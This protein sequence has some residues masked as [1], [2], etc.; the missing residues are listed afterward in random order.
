MKKTF[1]LSL[2]FCLAL[3]YQLQAQGFSYSGFKGGL[4]ISRMPMSFETA[5]FVEID[6][7]DLL[8]LPLLEVENTKANGKFQ[9]GGQFGVFAGKEFTKAIGVRMEL[10]YVEMGRVDTINFNQRNKYKLRYFS[11]DPMLQIRIAP[12]SRNHFY[13]LAGPSARLLIG[14]T[15]STVGNESNIMNQRIANIRQTDIGA[16]FGFSYLIELTRYAYLTL[17]ARAYYGLRN[18]AEKPKENTVATSKYVNAYNDLVT[19]SLSIPPRDVSEE[20]VT[21]LAEVQQYGVNDN[22]NISNQGA[23]FSIGFCVPLRPPADKL[24]KMKKQ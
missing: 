14:N 13:I 6:E 23:I 19:A 4:S 22:T 12:N 21:T 2:L 5:R 15:A 16:S 10:N 1:F 24:I 20:T 11:L 3:T 7:E 9:V 17:D 8:Q 18:I